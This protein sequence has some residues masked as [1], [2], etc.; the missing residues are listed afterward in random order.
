M[1][2]KVEYVLNLCLEAYISIHEMSLEDSLIRDRLNQF[3]LSHWIKV[4]SR[5]DLPE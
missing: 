2:M 3:Q 1:I 4:A 5:G